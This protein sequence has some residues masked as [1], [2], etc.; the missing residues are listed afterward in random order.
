MAK[1]EDILNKLLWRYYSDDEI[2]EIGSN[3]SR[4][5]EPWIQDFYA[6]WILRGL[7]QNETITWIKSIKKAIPAIAYQTLLQKAEKELPPHR[8]RIL[9][10]QLRNELQVA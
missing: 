2:K 8:F 10:F 1:E 6:T 9:S 7:N 3:I 4:S 5:V